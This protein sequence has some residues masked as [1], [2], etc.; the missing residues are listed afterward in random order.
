MQYLTIS[1]TRD[2]APVIREGHELRVEHVVT[3][4]SVERYGW[5]RLHPVPQHDGPIVRPGEEQSPVR[6]EAYS[7]DAAPV[8]P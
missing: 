7:V 5:H 1:S 3:V 4:P 8:L 2:N 6:V